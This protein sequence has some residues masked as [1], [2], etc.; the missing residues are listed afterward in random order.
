M[1]PTETIS[2]IAVLFDHKCRT[3]PTHVFDIVQKFLVD[4]SRSEAFEGNPFPP[5]EIVRIVINRN[6]ERFQFSDRFYGAFGVIGYVEV[7]PINTDESDISLACY[8]SGPGFIEANLYQ[9]GR[10]FLSSL[11]KHLRQKYSLD[12]PAPRSVRERRK[13]GRHHLDDDIWAWEQVNFHERP[14]ADVKKEW[15]NRPGVMGRNLVAPDRQFKRIMAQ[16][17]MNKS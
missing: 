16:G 1:E 10:R 5:L 8:G 13:P 9:A 14:P 12:N 6:T 3:T 7:A 2:D 15:M 11:A 4:F 17:W